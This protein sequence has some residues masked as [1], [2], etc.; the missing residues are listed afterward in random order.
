MRAKSM[1]PLT[2]H[3]PGPTIL[4]G[5]TRCRN[6]RGFVSLTFFVAGSFSI[7]AMTGC[8]GSHVATAHLDKYE[9]SDYTAT[10]SFNGDQ[11]T[12]IEAA[13]RA[14]EQKGFVVTLMAPDAG[15]L[16]AEWQGSS[17]IPEE[18]KETEVNERVT[19]L[20][21]ILGVLLFV[22]IIGIVLALSDSEEEAE[23]NLSG[24]SHSDDAEPVETTYL[25]VVTLSLVSLGTE[26]TDVIMSTEKK[27]LENGI[28]RTT[29]TMM[30]KYFNLSVFDETRAALLALQ[31]Q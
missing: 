28:E 19:V 21:V 22:L 5:Y 18:Q 17:V 6:H 7:Y 4:P 24:D 12:V 10:M 25:Y 8:S 20:H 2:T 26:S 1:V 9:A 11:Y 13:A 16:D 15:R 14:L 29:A 31:Q 27:I 30:N 3:R 23:A